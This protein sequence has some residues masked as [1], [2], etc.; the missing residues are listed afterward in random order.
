MVENFKLEALK[1]KWYEAS[2]SKGT[3][4][5]AL[6]PNSK[7]NVMDITSYLETSEDLKIKEDLKKLDIAYSPHINVDFSYIT[8]ENGKDI[9]HS[10]GGIARCSNKNESWCNLNITKASDPSMTSFW[11][12]YRTPYRIDFGP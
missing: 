2:R 1:G 10:M 5:E 8:N 12:D 4:V 6:H 3:T 11:S 9:P 7:C